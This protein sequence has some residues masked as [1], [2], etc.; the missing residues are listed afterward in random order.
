MYYTFYYSCRNNK[1]QRETM[2]K[3]CQSMITYNDR[4][5]G[6][7]EKER[8]VFLFAL[9]CIGC[10]R[11]DRY[12]LRGKCSLKGS[13]RPF[14]NHLGVLPSL[15]STYSNSRRCKN[16]YSVTCLIGNLTW[17]STIAVKPSISS[18]MYSRSSSDSFLAIKLIHFR[19]FKSSVGLSAQ[20]QCWFVLNFHR[21]RSFLSEYA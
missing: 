18:G 13:S 16:C 11:I 10:L 14:Y 15:C 4:Q 1:K 17:Y 8:D 20:N 19:G 21:P 12:C 6:R 2:E 7:I 3:T 9:H 5:W